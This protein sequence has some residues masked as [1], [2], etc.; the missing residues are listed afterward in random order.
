MSRD[1]R[2]QNID[3]PLG[4]AAGV[5][6]PLLPDMHI[7]VV[8]TLVPLHAY[9]FR[10]CPSGYYEARTLQRPLLGHLANT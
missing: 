1:I 4:M 8:G 7:S 9:L 6:Y 2:V 10:V 5:A 3:S